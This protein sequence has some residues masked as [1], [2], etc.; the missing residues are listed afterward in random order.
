MCYRAQH[1]KQVSFEKKKTI[2]GLHSCGSSFEGVEYM[3]QRCFEL[4]G[5]MH[6]PLV[7]CWHA[8]HMSLVVQMAY[9]TMFKYDGTGP[10]YFI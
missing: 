7:M 10:R 9:S 5:M 2:W 3:L 1:L 6:N 4:T 8:K